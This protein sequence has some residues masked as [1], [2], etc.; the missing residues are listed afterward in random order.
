[1]EVVRAAGHEHLALGSGRDRAADFVHQMRGLAVGHVRGLF[2]EPVEDQ[3]HVTQVHGREHRGRGHVCE[4]GRLAEGADHGVQS[5]QFAA[6]PGRQTAH[7]EI[8]GNRQV[9]ALVPALEH[10]PRE[11]AAQE[12]LSHAVVA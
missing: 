10:L 4:A 9:W 11:H 8:Q 6:L 12:S 1:M 3:G 2:V 7:V 5:G